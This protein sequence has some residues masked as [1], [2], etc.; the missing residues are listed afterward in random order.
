MSVKCLFKNKGDLNVFDD[1]FCANNYNFRMTGSCCVIDIG[2]NVG[3]ASLYFARMPTVQ[4]VHS[5]EPF[6]CPFNRALE[7]FALNPDIGVKIKPNHFGLSGT[8]E[9][10]EVSFSEDPTIGASIRGGAGPATDK[11]T[12]RDASATLRPIIEEA[13][14]NKQLVVIK[15]D[16]EGSEF[17]IVEALDRANLLGRVNVFMIQWHKLWSAD[18][19]NDDLA[20][21]LL[22]NGFA[23]FDF[24]RV[25]APSASMLFAAR[26][27]A[28]TGASKSNRCSTKRRSR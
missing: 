26:T 4:V 20:R 21:P 23:V 27:P 28:S 24:L 5:F 22:A 8:N 25:N 1:I 18:K 6:T 17:A 16:C 7:N 9:V 10:L 19:S 15:M 14:R 11:I 3:L 2:M 13:E 12:V